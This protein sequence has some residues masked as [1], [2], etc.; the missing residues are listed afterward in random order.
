[1]N[2]PMIQFILQKAMNNPAIANDPV[3]QQWLNIIVS[4]DSKRGEEIANN[5]CQAHG[6]SREDASNQ[7]KKFFGF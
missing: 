5:L 3:K 1:M 7:A 2:N 4:G 6:V